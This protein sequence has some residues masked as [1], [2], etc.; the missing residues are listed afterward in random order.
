MA[1]WLKWQ[2]S[3]QNALPNYLKIN[4]F[5]WR[6]FRN[7]FNKNNHGHSTSAGTWGIAL[8]PTWWF[9][10]RRRFTHMTNCI[11]LRRLDFRMENVFI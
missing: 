4:D 7:N 3:A 2:S 1:A 10:L 11:R 6:R 5:N 9:T 8:E